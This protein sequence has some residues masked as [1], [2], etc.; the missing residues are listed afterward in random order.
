MIVL[1]EGYYHGAEPKLRHASPRKTIWATGNQTLAKF[2]ETLY[3]IFEKDFTQMH[4]IHFPGDFNHMVVTEPDAARGFITIQRD[5]DY[6][7]WYK[8]NLRQHNRPREYDIDVRVTMQE[9]IEARHHI[10]GRPGY[11]NEGFSGSEYEVGSDE[12]YAKHPDYY[13]RQNK[14]EEDESEEEESE[15]D[16]IE[17][18]DFE[19]DESEEGEDAG[20]YESEGIGASETGR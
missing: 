16:E 15:E 2:K 19:V 18:D 13:S 12:E 7:R 6:A 11:S 10:V 20:S 14:S 17:E 1:N 3:D 8:A 4:Y 9:A 5:Q